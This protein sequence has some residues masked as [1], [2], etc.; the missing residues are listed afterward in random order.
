MGETVDER[1]ELESQP[2][3][4]STKVE[5]VTNA[6]KI[7]EKPLPIGLTKE[8]LMKYANDPF[9]CKLRKTLFALFWLLWLAMFLGA[10]LIIHY[11]PSC[12]AS[13]KL[14]WYQRGAY[15]EMDM[16]LFDNRLTGL[17]THMDTY[18]KAFG[19]D[20][21]LLPAPYECDS[22]RKVLNFHKIDQDLGSIEEFSRIV[23]NLKVTHK[24][25]VLVD[26][27]LSSTSI[28]HEWFKRF[29]AKDAAY[30][31]F[32]VKIDDVKKFKVN[33]RDYQLRQLDQSGQQIQILLYNGNPVLNLKSDRLFVELENSL[34]YWTAKGVRGFR[35]VNAPLVIPSLSTNG[36]VIAYT[37]DDELNRKFVAQ[38]SSLVKS[39]VSDAV[40]LLKFKEEPKPKQ[41]ALFYGTETEP[42]ADVVV[43]S[44]IADM[45]QHHH[46]NGN[47][48][49]QKLNEYLEAKPKWN[50]EAA[51]QGPWTG[52]VIENIDE[53]QQQPQQSPLA[54]HCFNNVL[55]YLIPKSAPITHVSQKLLPSKS[56]VDFWTQLDLRQTNGT[57]NQQENLRLFHQL[58]QLRAAN[59]E[60]V[61]LGSIRFPFVNDH[62]FTMARFSTTSGLL[63]LANL[64]KRNPTE[65]QL[66]REFYLPVEG[67]VQFT[68]DSSRSSDETIALDGNVSLRGGEVLIVRF[69]IA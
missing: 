24:V 32:Y 66:N 25:N 21:W 48:L 8:E 33:D 17:L 3:N 67:K 53:Q 44:L 52:W 28:E 26:L 60:S 31:D 40:L 14:R 39:L 18:S 59:V 64:D 12:P 46:L 49:Q 15:S 35:L 68:C 69:E 54:F 16:N 45:N 27:D 13:S 23:S 38:L 29:L 9:W 61:L 10:F 47:Q 58:N 1:I 41:S 36:E 37:F 51:L 11:V 56:I 2:L 42:I 62:V 6:N 19:F 34:R 7:K 22:N 63:V 4:S 43:S 55:G 5:I 65:F 30:V 20:N 50:G 57:L